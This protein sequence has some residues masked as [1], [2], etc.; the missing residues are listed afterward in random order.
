MYYSTV[1]HE[2]KKNNGA[3]LLIIVVYNFISI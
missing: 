3:Q 2:F 1:I